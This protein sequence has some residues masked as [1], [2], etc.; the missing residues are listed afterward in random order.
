MALADFMTLQDTSAYR[1]G[2]ETLPSDRTG[3]DIFH[4]K[5]ANS[6]DMRKWK[7]K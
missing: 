7:V 6:Y 2:V 5:I 4:A 1:A 3:T